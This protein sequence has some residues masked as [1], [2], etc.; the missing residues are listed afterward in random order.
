MADTV[1]KLKAS[2]K[3]KGTLQ[4]RLAASEKSKRTELLHEKRK[5]NSKYML[6]QKKYFRLQVESKAA[7]EKAKSESKEEIKAV[8]GE[9]RKVCRELL[10]MEINANKERLRAHH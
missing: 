6:L 7:V 5:A 9:E 8:R 10:A 1:R 2:E 3:A 4:R